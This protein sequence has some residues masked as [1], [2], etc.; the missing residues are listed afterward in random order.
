MVGTLGKIARDVALLM[1]TEVGEVAE[2]AGQGR[3]GSSAMPHKRNP[4]ASAIILAAAVRVPALVSTMLSAMVQ[5]HER[6]LGGWQ[7]EWETIPEIYRL[8]AV[9]LARTIEI[10][11]GLEVDAARMAANLEATGGV[12][13]SEAVSAALSASMGRAEAHELLSGL[14]AAP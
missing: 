12:V 14:H 11:S 8:G 4:V 9:A 7:A 3:G 1:Q 13:M 2:P 5:E 10:A 6:A